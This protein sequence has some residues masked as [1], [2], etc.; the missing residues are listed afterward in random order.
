MWG[1]SAAMTILMSP[2]SRLRGRSLKPADTETNLRD[3]RLLQVR[4]DARRLQGE[5]E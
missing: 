4:A 5:R 1:T 3:S 2:E